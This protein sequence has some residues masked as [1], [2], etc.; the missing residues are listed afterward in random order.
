VIRNNG[1]T[2]EAIFNRK[3][4][5]MSKLTK[6][7]CVVVLQLFLFSVAF[8]G[9]ADADDAPPRNLIIVVMGGAS[10]K[11]R[12]EANAM[13]DRLFMQIRA[14]DRVD[15][16][17]ARSTRRIAQ[18]TGVPTARTV[19]QRNRAY[20]EQFGAV[21][22]FIDETP[23]PPEAEP[24]DLNIPAVLDAIA[25]TELNALPGH[26]AEVLMI[27]SMMFEDHRQ[28]AFRMTG[29]GGQAQYPSDAHLAVDH[30]V[31]PYGIRGREAAL[32]GARVHICYVPPAAGFVTDFFREAVESWWWKTLSGQ[33]AVVGT[34]APAS[35]ACTDRF[36]VGTEYPV[37]YKLDGS[38]PQPRMIMIN[39]TV[40]AMPSMPPPVPLFA[41][42]LCTAPAPRN[43]TPVWVGIQ[44]TAPVDLDLWAREKATA[45]WLFFAHRMPSN[46]GNGRF[47]RDYVTPTGG[48]AYELID[49][50]QPLKLD[51]LQVVVNLYAGNVPP[52]GVPFTIRFMVGNCAYEAHLKVDSS[53]G[54]GGRPPM[55]AP[56]WLPV[57]PLDVMSLGQGRV[58]TGGPVPPRPTQG[59]MPAART[60][61]TAI[62]PPARP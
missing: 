58:T 25:S 32:K 50:S 28:P 24:D 37:T 1:A 20:G 16:I 12:Y 18:I 11:M 17:D 10:Q 42:Q 26:T 9:S 40:P 49:F 53:V 33:G 54:N 34:I 60:A 47:D 4:I 19:V 6:L 21:R 35:G 5:I 59:A 15:F 41:A 8:M 45:E 22:I 14:G 44:W 48:A 52:G 39:P 27:G 31:S 62:Q 55:Q 2:T 36:F 3:R 23:V 61:E 56:F 46:G 51:E 30:S 7:T 57:R 43:P 38:D 29:P 13:L